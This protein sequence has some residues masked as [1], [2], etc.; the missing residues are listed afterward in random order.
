MTLREAVL[1][2]QLYLH[3]CLKASY[4]PGKGHGPVNHAAPLF[5]QSEWGK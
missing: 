2:S 3:T 4:N 5:S 1:R